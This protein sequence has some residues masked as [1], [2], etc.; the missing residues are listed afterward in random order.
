MKFLSANEAVVIFHL[1]LTLFFLCNFHC[2][3]EPPPTLIFIVFVPLL[4]LPPCEKM[5]A[6]NIIL[7]SLYCIWFD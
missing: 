2:H 5:R 6:L 1:I 3:L 4:V 7:E